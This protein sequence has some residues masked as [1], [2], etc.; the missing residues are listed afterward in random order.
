MRNSLFIAFIFVLF[1]F[2]CGNANTDPAANAP[3][4]EIKVERFDSA[5]FSIDTMHTKSAIVKLLQEHPNFSE[6]FITRILMLKQLDDTNSIKTFYKTYLPIYK[7]V[8]NIN[9]FKV[10]KPALESS[11]KRLHFYFPKYKLTHNVILFV[12]P[13]E[14]YGNIITNDGIAVGLQMHMGASSK[15]YY[16]EHIQT[17]YPSYLSRRYTPD[18]IAISSVQ[19]ILSD[20]YLP[21]NKSQSLVAQMIEAGKIQYII[22]ACFPSTPD[23]VKLG[24]SND[25]C[26]NLKSQEGQ[27]WSYLLHEKLVF[28]TNPSDIDNFMQDAASSNT[29]GEALPGNIGKY[30]GFKIVNAWMQQKAQKEISMETLLNTPSDKI[31]ETAAYNP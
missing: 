16:D 6:D 31:F 27:V 20:I 3:N 15:W 14:S 18:Y 4:F 26:I 7:E 8:Q 9:A 23:S 21:P 17:I 24:Y 19:N 1:M 5:F 29:F 22:N 13:L 11:F 25:Q 28:S 12:G 10:A 2:G 30:I